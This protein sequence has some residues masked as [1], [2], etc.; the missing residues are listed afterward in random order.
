MPAKDFRGGLKNLRGSLTENERKPMT[1]FGD[2]QL[3]NP[4][5]EELE[6]QV[7]DLPITEISLG[8]LKD[9]PY[10]QLARPTIDPAAIEELASSIRQNGFYGALLARPKYDKPGF[11]ELAYGH[12]RRDAAVQAGLTRL[13]VKVLDL[14]DIQMARVMASENFSREDL[15]PLGEAGVIGH[16]Y[17]NQNMTLGDI[18]EVIGKKKGWVQLRLALSEAPADL[19]ALV[20][21]KP[22]TLSLIPLLVQLKESGERS[23]FIQKIL[24]GKLNRAGLQRQVERSK[25]QITGDNV[26]DF[27]INQPLIDSDKSN[28]NILIN[29]QSLVRDGEITETQTALKHLTME[30]DYL[31]QLA[32]EAGKNLTPAEKERV[33]EIIERLHRLL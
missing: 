7:E 22:D 10:Q 29:G 9:N 8:Q 12:R 30:V 33:I 24:A 3:G 16:L 23:G 2:S 26:T 14:S 6:R 1:V 19:K 11:Y 20:E 28:N 21:Q 5:R 32:G 15:T 4:F 27:T 25:R 31:E 17:N 18:A 13:P